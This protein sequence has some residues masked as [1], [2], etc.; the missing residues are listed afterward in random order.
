VLCGVEVPQDAN[1]IVGIEGFEDAGV[2]R[3]TDEIAL[4]QTIDFFTPVV[5]DPYWFG[6]IAAANALSDIYA[7]GAVPKTAM[8]I[9]CFSPKTYGV[10]TLREII[11][12]GIDKIREAGASLM[13]GHSVQDEEIKY[14]LSVTGLVHPEKILRNEGALPGDV[15]ILTKPLGTGILNTAIKAD[16]V[17]EDVLKRLIAVMAQLNDK[18]AEVMRL[19]RTHAATDVTGFGL[20]GHL[21]EMIK[22]HVGVELYPDR[23]P[24]FGQVAELCRS[25]F[26]PAGLYRNRDFYRPC[27][28]GSTKDFLYDLLFDPQTSGGL[29]M[30]VHP[31]DL[32]IFAAIAHEKGVEFWPIGQFRDEPKGKIVLLP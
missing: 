28:S 21:S 16:L 26:V 27:V 30:A 10:D 13:G 8:N 9:V 11:R 29:L 14:G 22:D 15:L 7:M 17:A 3:I 2:Y 20:V 18:A 5:D 1:V 24:Y 23:L 31:D 4:V 19:V 12:G 6:Q 32:E 25:G